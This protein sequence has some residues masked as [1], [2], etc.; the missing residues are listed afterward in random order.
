MNVA[1]WIIQGILTALFLFAGGSKW[2]MTLEQ[3]TQGGGVPLPLWFFRFIGAC[4]VLGALG[5][6][7]PGL[8]R[9]KRGLTPLAACGL[10]V[11]MIG[12]TGVTL[13]GG[14]RAAA[15]IPFVVGILAAFVVYGRRQWLSGKTSVKA[16]R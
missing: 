4:E 1:L 3:M 10:I 16:N 5:L 6:S 14:P 2:M 11:I 12:A 13:I 7:L 8:F 15:P 9:I